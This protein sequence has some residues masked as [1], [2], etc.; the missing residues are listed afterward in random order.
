MWFLHIDLSY[1]DILKYYNQD[2]DYW[3]H[4]LYYQWEHVLLNYDN[5]TDTE[6]VP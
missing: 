4:R 2:M 1:G 6:L 5:I 3:T